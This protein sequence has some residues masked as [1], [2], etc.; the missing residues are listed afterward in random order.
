MGVG[1]ALAIIFGLI[2]LIW[3]T[4]GFKRTKHKVLA[5]VL[6]AVVLFGYF[7][8]N[9]VFKDKKADISNFEGLKETAKVYFSWFAS[10]FSNVKSFTAHVIGWANET[11]VK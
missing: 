7:S 9:F 2:F 4:A 11:Q 1:I 10:A 8:L 5:F 6:I 3:I